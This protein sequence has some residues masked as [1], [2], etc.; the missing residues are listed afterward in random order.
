MACEKISSFLGYRFRDKPEDE[1]RGL[2]YSDFA[3]LLRSV[4]RTTLLRLLRLC[5]R[6]TSQWSFCRHGRLFATP[7]AQPRPRSSVS[8]H[9]TPTRQQ[10][11]AMLDADLGV[12]PATLDEAI[13]LWTPSASGIPRS[14]SLSITCK[15]TFLRFLERIQLREETVPNGR[16]E[17]VYYNLGKFSQV[18][19]DYEQIHFKERSQAEY[20]GFSESFATRPRITTQRAAR[21]RAGPPLTPCRS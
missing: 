6:V 14:A 13:A 15:R 10:S 7:E 18:I 16:G 12:D 8:W 11:D 3:V 9:G 17:L 4:Q 21:M 1:P 20:E 2:A 19:S 5:A